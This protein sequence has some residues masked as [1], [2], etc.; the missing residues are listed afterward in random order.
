MTN[1][2]G[3][4]AVSAAA[5]L[6]SGSAP[7]SLAGGSPQR[8]PD[9]ERVQRAAAEARRQLR[10][11]WMRETVDERRK[12]DDRTEERR[13]ARV[14]AVTQ[15]KETAIRASK[16]ARMGAPRI[17]EIEAT[18]AAQMDGVD[19]SELVDLLNSETRILRTTTLDLR[20]RRIRRD[21]A[22]LRDLDALARTHGLSVTQRLSVE[23][24]GS[25]ICDGDKPE[26]RLFP[27]VEKL[28]TIVPSRSLRID[29]ELKK[30][31]IVPSGVFDPAHALSCE[32]TDG[33]AEVRLIG[34]D[35]EGATAFIFTLSPER[36]FAVTGLTVYKGGRVIEEFTASDYR[37]VDGVWIPYRTRTVLSE[38]GPS[39]YVC[40]RRVE[41]VRVNQTL[42][43]SDEL[44][45]IP[46]SYRVQ[47]LTRQ[48]SSR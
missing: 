41:E 45:A 31:G 13:A 20:N 1:V 24:S 11:L 40:E 10:T 17:E 44:F 26:V 21:D 15:W 9:V 25:T 33:D 12:F 18:A 48:A 36:R 39:Y 23:K 47:D 14:R 27:H 3:A 34:R 30:L 8:Q 16:A 6:L 4:F 2:R 22:D 43:D 7:L 29:T 46:S 35:A 5:L 38:R 28:A 42:G 19:E 32:G 37:E